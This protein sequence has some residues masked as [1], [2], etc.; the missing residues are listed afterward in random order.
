[1]SLKAL[2]R[3][4]DLLRG[5][6]RPGELAVLSLRGDNPQFEEE[7]PPSGLVSRCRVSD[8][9]ASF[10]TK[11]NEESPSC[12]RGYLRGPGRDVSREVTVHLAV[13]GCLLPRYLRRM[14]P[15]NQGP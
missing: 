10:V 7:D 13:I 3:D 2:S 6:G 4:V 1:M 9:L 14:F 12:C 15:P 8:H 5:G 11:V